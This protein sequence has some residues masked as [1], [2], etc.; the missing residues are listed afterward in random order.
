MH[1]A[2]LQAKTALCVTLIIALPQ[3]KGSLPT[4]KIGKGKPNWEKL[5]TLKHSKNTQTCMKTEKTASSQNP[6]VEQI[7]VFR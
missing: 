6:G 3:P 7:P 5:S 2:T 1:I 4:Q